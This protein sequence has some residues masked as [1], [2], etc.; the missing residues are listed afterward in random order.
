MRQNIHDI[1]RPFRFVAFVA[2]S[3]IDGKHAGNRMSGQRTAGSKIAEIDH[4]FPFRK[5]RCRI[6][7]VTVQ[8]EMIPTGRLP[9]DIDD[10]FG[11]F[12]GL[13]DHFGIGTDDLQGFGTA[14]TNGVFDV[15]DGAFDPPIGIGIVFT[16]SSVFLSIT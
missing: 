13:T 5:L 12:S 3:V 7:F 6:A 14:T 4:P 15:T 9:H 16:T 8:T 2:F 10:Q 11:F 1:L